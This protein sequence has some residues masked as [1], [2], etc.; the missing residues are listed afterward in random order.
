M[1]KL[2]SKVKQPIYSVTIDISNVTIVINNG[3]IVINKNP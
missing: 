3:T 2:M 1:F